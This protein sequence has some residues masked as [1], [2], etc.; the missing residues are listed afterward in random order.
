MWRSAVWLNGWAVFT[1]VCNS[2]AAASITVFL[3]GLLKKNPGGKTAEIHH[4]G[5]LKMLLN[6]WCLGYN[7]A[8]GGSGGGEAPGNDDV[9]AAHTAAQWSVQGTP[10]VPHLWWVSLGQPQK[11]SPG[12][13]GL[14]RRICCIL[15]TANLCARNAIQQTAGEG[16]LLAVFRSQLKSWGCSED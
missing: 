12:G 11:F 2:L 1:L 3:V 8:G 6:V 15:T 9:S 16:H 7:I 10:C 4:C 5:G 14:V 13:D